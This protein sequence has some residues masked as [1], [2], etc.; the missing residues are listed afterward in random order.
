MGIEDGNWSIPLQAA[1]E[2]I[3]SRDLS[4]ALEL[5]L[6]AVDYDPQNVRLINLMADCYYYLGEFDRAEACWQEVLKID[7]HN[8]TTKNHLSRF[9]TPTFQ[10]WLKRYRRAANYLEQ[11]NYRLAL[12]ALREVME[13][14]D[15]FVSVYQLL[16]LCYM[17]SSDPEQARIVWQ[18]GLLLDSSNEAL[19]RYMDTR[20]ASSLEM[21]SEPATDNSEP[22]KN[23]LSGKVRWLILK[24]PE[25]KTIAAI[26][27][28]LCLALLLQG[29]VMIRN[30]HSSKAAMMEMQTRLSQLSHQL[31]ETETKEADS[32]STPVISN[33]MNYGDTDSAEG[34]NYD[35]DKEK[36]YYREGYQAYQE[37]NYDKAMQNLSVVVAMKSGD[38]IN[39][40]AL[41][42][43]A[44]TYYLKTDFA[45]AEKYYLKYVD[46]FPGTNYHDDSLF[47][48]AV[49]YYNDDKPTKA[50][51]SLQEMKRVSP[52]SGYESSEFYQKIMKANI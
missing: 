9:R 46:E 41:Y 40:E 2:K 27:G 22:G 28:V 24:R 3:Q 17:A 13:E 48:L 16:G 30:N 4:G 12:S 10:S 25:P 39:R 43:L 33:Q 29:G 6:E 14:N 37:A 19:L 7:P 21:M 51:Q 50:L 8:S 35:L 1:I 38:Y 44:R 34:S 31:E 23:N 15:G 20:A 49:I 26:A 47:F 32:S 36:Q 11:K 42:Y 45:E 52:D 5:L 18:R